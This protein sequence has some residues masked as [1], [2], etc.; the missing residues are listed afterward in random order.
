MSP[1]VQHW[2]LQVA[3]LAESVSQIMSKLP[4]RAK[5]QVRVD[6]TSSNAVVSLLN[7]ARGQIKSAMYALEHAMATA[8]ALRVHLTPGGK[9]MLPN[10]IALKRG[11]R[12][13]G[14]I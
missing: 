9:S 7:I 14:F 4:G 8:A 12:G 10:W 3:V 13:I 2:L 5:S 1:L 6:E 11:S